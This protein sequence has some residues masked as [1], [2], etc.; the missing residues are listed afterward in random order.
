VDHLDPLV[1]GRRP[2]VDHHPHLQHELV[3]HQVV[4]VLEH[5]GAD[6]GDRP[7]VVVDVVRLQP[8]GD[9]A[10]LDDVPDGAAVGL[11]L[12]ADQ[13][14][15]VLQRASRIVGEVD[16]DLAAAPGRARHLEGQ[17]DHRG[18]LLGGGDGVAIDDHEDGVE[19]HRQRRVERVVGVVALGH[20]RDGDAGL[21]VRVVQH[22][23][24]E[25]LA[26]LGQQRRRQ[27]VQL[28]GD[29]VG[30]AVALDVQHPGLVQVEVGREPVVWPQHLHRCQR[31]GDL[32]A[33]RGDERAIG[34]ELHE[35]L[36][37]GVYHHHHAV[38][39]ELLDGGEQSVV[40]GEGGQRRE[41]DQQQGDDGS[42]GATLYPR[43]G[44]T[45]PTRTPF[46]PRWRPG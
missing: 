36:T 7:R 9:A 34:V 40:L 45:S 20:P 37:L 33:R 31:S 39:G 23:P 43:R 38:A 14:P 21:E 28:L 13:L 6:L 12:G 46:T 5:P 22:Q 10:D 30:V 42:H 15:G 2:A 41:Q 3:G 27:Q 44:W 32:E 26:T 29:Q 11:E 17:R 4:A 24:G 18:L 1:E 25:L 19:V 8:V 16:A 35:G